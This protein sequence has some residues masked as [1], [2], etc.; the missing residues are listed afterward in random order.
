MKA[1]SVS[2]KKRYKKRAS[3]SYRTATTAYPCYVPILGD[4]AGAGRMRLAQ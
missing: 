2:M 4:S 1:I 3:Y